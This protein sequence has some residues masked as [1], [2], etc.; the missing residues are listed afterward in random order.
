[1]LLLFLAKFV[2]DKGAVRFSGALRDL[3]RA[4]QGRAAT[5]CGHSRQR[6]AVYPLPV[7]SPPT[8]AQ[9]ALGPHGLLRSRRRLKTAA[10]RMLTASA[11]AAGGADR[12]HAH[13]SQPTPL[14][15]HCPKPSVGFANLFTGARRLT[16]DSLSVLP[17]QDGVPADGLAGW[18]WPGSQLALDPLDSRPEQIQ[19]VTSYQPESLLLHGS[20]APPADA[21]DPLSWLQHRYAGNLRT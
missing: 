5:S 10:T 19:G 3:Q 11:S 2:C 8:V 20:V 1:M 15:A 13:C 9:P 6:T 12:S 17:G 21:P 14:F 16:V 7:L 18:V 4:S